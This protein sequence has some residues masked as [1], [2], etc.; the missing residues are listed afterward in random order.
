[1]T[2]PKPPS[3]MSLDELRDSR[4]VFVEDRARL[5][6]E[7]SELDQENK[8]LSAELERLDAE[9]AARFGQDT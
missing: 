9:I 3:E 4:L 8:R 7:I 5:Q 2:E 6:G 1:M